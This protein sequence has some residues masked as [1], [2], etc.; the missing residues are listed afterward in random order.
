MAGSLAAAFGPAALRFLRPI[1]V[2]GRGGGS[3]LGFSFYNGIRHHPPTIIQHAYLLVLLIFAVAPLPAC[4]S[5]PGLL[6]S[7]E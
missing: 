4:S 1:L 7:L 3:Y 6:R 2:V 5:E